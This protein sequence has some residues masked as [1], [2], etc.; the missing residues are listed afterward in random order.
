M[1]SPGEGNWQPTLVF[2]PGKSRGDGAW[3]AT[4][5]HGVTKD[6]D[7]TQPLNNN[8]SHLKKEVVP[9]KYVLEMRFIHLFFLQLLAMYSCTKI[10]SQIVPSLGGVV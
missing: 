8:K 9:I 5:T 6:L 10:G 7:T 2:L 1:Q 4:T 3:W